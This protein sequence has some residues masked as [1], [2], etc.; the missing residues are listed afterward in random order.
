MYDFVCAN[1]ASLGKSLTTV[2]AGVWFFTS[3]SAFMSLE[4]IVMSFMLILAGGS[5]GKA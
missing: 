4:K 5:I 3:V 2:T 1:I